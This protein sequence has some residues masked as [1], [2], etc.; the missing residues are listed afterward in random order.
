[1]PARGYG[2]ERRWNGEWVACKC[3]KWGAWC[4]VN[5]LT[6]HC[7][8]CGNKWPAAILRKH[9]VPE[10][11]DQV[12]SYASVVKGGASSNEKVDKD[13]AVQMLE[14]LGYEVKAPPPEKAASAATPS[15]DEFYAEYRTACAEAQKAI[16]AEQHA[17][18]NLD[19]AKEKL[20]K[21]QTEHNTKCEERTKALAKARAASQACCLLDSPNAALDG[22][23]LGTPAAGQK[24]ATEFSPSI[25]EAIIKAGVD[26]A[27]G[28][29]DS[30]MAII[31]QV[32]GRIT[33]HALAASMP[34]PMPPPAADNAEPPDDAMPVD[35]E[36]AG[37]EPDAQ[38]VK[39]TADSEEEAAKRRKAEAMRTKEEC[40]RLEKLAAAT[41][42]GAQP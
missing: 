10:S 15:R 26:P 42:G 7:Q 12:D 29:R 20:A 30:L 2:N 22:I 13:E 37:A 5:K 24:V 21:L 19:A 6:T 36:G 25:D 40:D 1:M 34:A 35:V 4:Y 17:K 11:G 9:G 14:K 8:K 38:G 16:T 27:A 28:L 33:E 31:H 32:A 41:G 3:G 18:K 23:G 39:R